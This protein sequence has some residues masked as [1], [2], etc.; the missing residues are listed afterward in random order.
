MCGDEL[1]VQLV[2]IP[3]EYGGL[4]GGAFDVYRVCE[5]L[6][7]DRH[8]AWPPSCSPPSS[9][10]TPSWSARPPSSARNGSGRDRRAGHPVRLRR[11]RAR[12]RQRPRR[13]DAPRPPRSRPTDEVTAYRITGRK[14]WISNGSI[15]DVYTILALAPGGPSWFVVEKGRRASRRHRRRTSTASGCPTPPRCSSTTSSCRRRTWSAGVEGRGLI[16]AQQVFGYT[17]V[18]VAAF[19]LGGGWAALDRAIAYSDE[20]GPGRRPAVREAG[21]HPQADRAARGPAGGGAR[22]PRGD[23]DADRR[24]RG[25]RR[26]LNTEG[27]IAKYLATEAGNAAA[28]AAIQAHGGYG[29]TRDVPGRED[30]AGRPDHHDLR[31]HVGDPGDDDR[32]GPLAAAP[33]DR[34]RATTATRPAQLDGAARRRAAAAPRRW[35]WTCLAAVLE[36]CRVGRLTRNQHVLLRLGEL[37]AYAECAGALARRAAAA[38][39]GTL[40]DKADTRFDAGGAGR[41][42]PGLRPGGRAARSPRRACGWVA[43]ADGGRR[44]PAP[45][46]G[47][48]RWTGSGPRRPACSPT[49][50]SVA[51]ALYG[52]AAPGGIDDDQPHAPSPIAVVGIGAIMPDAPDAA[53]VLGQH[54]DR[55]LQHQRRAAGALGSGAVLRPGPARAGQDLLAHRRLGPRLRLGPDGAGGCRSRRRS[56][57]QMDDGQKWAVAAARAALLDA[58]WPDWTVDPERVAVILGNAIGGEKHYAQ[59]P[60]D[61]VPRV[62]RASCAPRRRSRR[63]RTTCATPSLAETRKSFL[64]GFAEITED[65]MPGELAN[66]I[67]GRVA[68]LFN[69][70][71]PNF[72]TDAA[73]ASG[74]AAMSAA[75]RGL[76]ADDFDAAVTGGVDRNMGAAAF[77]KFCKIGALS[78]TGTRPFDAGADGFVMGEGAALFVLKRLADAERDGDRIYAVLLGIAGVQRRQG[79]GHHRAQPG[80]SAARRRAGLA[81]RRC[82]P[83]AGRPASR[84]TARR[85]G[86]ATPTEL[87]SLDRRVRQGRRGRR[88]DRARLGE[89]QHRPPQGARPAPPGCSRRCSACTRRC[90]R[91]ACTSSD[92]NPN[93]D[94]AHSPFRV[95]TE[96]REWPAPA[97]GVR[98]AGV[99]AFGFGGTNF[100]AVLEE[101][102]P[103]RH[104]DAGRARRSFAGGDG[105]HRRPRRSTAARRDAEAARRKAPL[106]GALVVGG[107]DDA[108]ARRAAARGCTP[109][110]RPGGHPPRPRRT[111]RWPAPPCGSRS[112]TPT[113]PSWP[114]RRARRSRRCAAG[115]PA[116][117]RMLRAQGVFVGRGARRRRSRSSTPARAR[118][119][120]TC[121][122]TLRAA[123]A[124]RGR[125][126]R[127]GRPGHDA[128]ARPAADRR[129]S[130]STPPTRPPRSGSSSS[131]MQTEITQPAV[132]ATDL[133]LTRLLAAYGV[134][135]D[136]VMGHSLGE[137]GALVAAGALSFDA[138]LEAVSARGR[139]MASLSIDDNGAMAAVFAPARRRSSGSSPRP[140]AT[141]SSPTST[142]PARRSSAAPPTRSS[143]PIDG[144]PGGR[145]HRDPDP[146]QP[147]L[148]HLDRGAGQRAAEGR[149]AP[150][151]RAAAAPADR[152]RT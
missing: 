141:S 125:D 117:W 119:T 63:C 56:A 62:R 6:A 135:P 42:Q 121:C 73:C 77:V 36:A 127:R 108:D 66:V 148:P 10:A 38:A 122:A 50:T 113:P 88:L 90:C 34:R 19:G 81:A 58:G 4:G 150:A 32:P 14:Q 30:Q 120:S 139:E 94:W 18:M 69:F 57:T 93:V 137:Y 151:R 128:A 138:A 67:A 82:R 83:G 2:F 70:R 61:R 43:G 111:P 74:L 48:C 60:A 3:E 76:Q 71:G 7:R 68:N 75:V 46:C 44:R 98:C 134:R 152:R 96:L 31:G 21:L 9:A 91:P 110:P 12:G 53:D 16:Q 28:E 17:R 104:R 8:R 146:G 24:R 131:C 39:A 118:S 59:Q 147:R 52:R 101:Y 47:R 80:R 89:V 33:Q 85:P 15:A 123:R 129:T 112:T 149:A 114:P 87:E 29:Y 45:A 13:D 144:V 99:S 84:R 37:I 79:Q 115:N 26:A 72:T 102:V 65:T 11:H 25:R 27:A 23:R 55:P 51:D 105:R 136:M 145:P 124:D 35:R 142:A 54:Q 49:W 78:A 133:A 109:T 86:S 106:R 41:D 130:S 95:N 100:H 126:V 107:A 20:P 64:A 5:R 97:S 140:T 92:P 116:M 40:P 132:L 143:G 1:G 22:V 103:G